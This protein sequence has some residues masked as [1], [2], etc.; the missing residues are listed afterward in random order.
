MFR[1]SGWSFFKMSFQD[2]FFESL[3]T[4]FKNKGVDNRFSS[5]EENSQVKTSNTMWFLVLFCF[6]NGKNILFLKLSLK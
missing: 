4:F 3:I 1:F 2:V 6:F 5:I